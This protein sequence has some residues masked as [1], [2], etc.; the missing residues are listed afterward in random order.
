MRDRA[1]KDSPDQRGLL[2]RFSVWNASACRHDRHACSRTCNSLS[3]P[4]CCQRKRNKAF[5]SYSRLPPALSGY[6]DCQPFPYYGPWTYWWTL[7]ERDMDVPSLVLKLRECSCAFSE[8]LKPPR[9]KSSASP[10]G[11][12][13]TEPRHDAHEWP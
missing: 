12:Q 7:L 3:C 8:A 6:P 4:A 5:W 13:T 10:L 11:P 2:L 1:G 9:D